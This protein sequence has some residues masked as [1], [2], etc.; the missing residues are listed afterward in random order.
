MQ[1]AERWIL[2]RLRNDTFFSLPPANEAVA[3]GT[4]QLVTIDVPSLQ[5]SSLEIASSDPSIGERASERA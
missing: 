3:A 2:A 1:V 5:A 4:M